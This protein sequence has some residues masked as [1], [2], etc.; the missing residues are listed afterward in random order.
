MADVAPLGLGIEGTP[1]VCKHDEGRSQVV[2]AP[3]EI[4]TAV[5]HHNCRKA[6]QSG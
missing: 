2:D 1:I 3:K 4:E 6:G 5:C